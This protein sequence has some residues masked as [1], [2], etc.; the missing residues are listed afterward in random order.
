MNKE[1]FLK[2]LQDLDLPEAEISGHRHRLKTALLDSGCWNK[3]TTMLITKKFAPVG[4]LAAVALIAVFVNLNGSLSSVSAEEL[5]KKS[6]RV[7][8][9]LPADRQE[10]LKRMFGDDMLSYLENAG[11]A[12]DLKVLSSDEYIK[13][14]NLPT[15]A[16]ENLRNMKFMQYAGA[17][18]REVTIGVDQDNSQVGFMA[19]TGPAAE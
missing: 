12:E 5:A 4:I 1:H 18:G 11:K 8:S 7:M 3:K 13:Q 6:Y 16:A 2:E 15:E 17:D 10:E 9:E 19:T 14:R